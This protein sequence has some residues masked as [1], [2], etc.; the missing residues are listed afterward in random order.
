MQLLKAVEDSWLIHLYHFRYQLSQQE[1]IVFP[2]LNFI[3]YL[4]NLRAAG[5]EFLASQ[6]L[7]HCQS[8][9]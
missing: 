9:D 6:Q 7:S 1:F 8:S 4:K 2:F 5:W 3:L